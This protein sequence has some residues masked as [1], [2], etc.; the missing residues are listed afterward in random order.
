MRFAASKCF[1][2]NAIVK[3]IEQKRSEGHVGILTI[4]DNQFSLMQIYYGR[5]EKEK[6]TF[7]PVMIPEN[8][9]GCLIYYTQK[10]N[11]LSRSF[12]ESKSKLVA[13]D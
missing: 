4:A 8:S 12:V 1:K 2:V 11:R 5:K 7:H 6:T 10:Q 3:R 13:I 9:P